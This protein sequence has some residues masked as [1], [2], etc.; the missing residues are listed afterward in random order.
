MS[1][2]NKDGLAYRGGAGGGKEKEQASIQESIK[3]YLLAEQFGC[4]E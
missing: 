1:V 3:N 2:L 4:A